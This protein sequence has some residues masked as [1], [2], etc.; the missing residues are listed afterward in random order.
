MGCLCNNCGRLLSERAERCCGFRQRVVAVG[1]DVRGASDCRVKNEEEIAETCELVRGDRPE[2]FCWPSCSR[3]IPQHSR[4]A[5]ADPHFP[6]P[7]FCHSPPCSPPHPS[8]PQPALSS[9]PSLTTLV[10]ACRARR[11]TAQALRHSRARTSTSLSGSCARRR[12]DRRFR[13]QT[14]RRQQ[15]STRT[16]GKAHQR[17]LRATRIP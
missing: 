9:Q 8:H 2:G 6:R 13:A 12:R 15:G 14:S 11:S 1:G 4:L 10:A 17:T 3:A 7:A 16:P 5:S